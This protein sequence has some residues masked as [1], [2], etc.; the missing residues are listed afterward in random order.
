MVDER[1][2]VADVKSYIDKL[3]NFT[4]E[5]EQH[6][7]NLR[8]DLSVYYDNKL[9]F[10]AEFK[11]PTTIEGRSPRNI[12]VVRDAF[13]KANNNNPPSRFFATSNFNETIIWD[14]SDNTKPLISRDVYTINLDNKIKKDDDFNKNEIKTE[15]ESKMQALAEYIRDLYI[16][17]KK[18]YYKPLGD[19]FILGLN[20]HLNTAV[21]VVKR[22]VPEN[23]LRKWWDEQGY[24]PK[25]T[26]CDE[27][28]EKISKYSLY[29]FANKIVFYY[30]LKRSFNSIGDIK[31]ND[32]ENIKDLENEINN[33][34]E[35]AKK[36]SGDYE[37]VFENNDAD[38]ILFIKDE[39]SYPILLLIKFL[40]VYDFTK[41][42]QELLGNIYDRLIS[43]DERHA[44]GQYYTPIPV[45]DLINALTIKNK[46]SRVMDPACGSGT[47]LTRAFDLK[48][49]L[50]N[51]DNKEIRENIMKEL[52]GCDISAYPA[53]LATIALASKLL[54]YN[55]DVYPN[56]IR[57][58]FLNLKTSNVIPKLRTEFE[59]KKDILTT[60]L[61]GNK[62]IVSFKP[63]DAFVG[64]LPYIRDEDLQNKDA[65][66]EK[67]EKFLKENGFTEAINEN[68]E[69]LYMP[70]KGADFYLYFWYYILPFLKEGSMIG[71]LTSDTWMN[72][73]YGDGFKKFI[74]KY[75]KIKY[76]IDSSV[77]RWF[78]DALVNTVITVLERTNSRTER[79]DN[80]IKFVRINRKISEII[81]D[82]DD[83]IHI[84]ETIEKDEKVDGINII[85]KI[86]QGSI[87]FND[88]MKGKLFPYLRGPE[89]FLEIV[90]NKNM[91][92]INKIMNVN[93]G[94]TTGANQFFYVI[95]VTN[96]YSDEQLKEFFGLRRGERN[97][98]MV[99]KDGMGTVHL[100]EAE[101]L[102]PILKG[103][104]EFTQP[105][106]L[107][108]NDPTKKYVV[109]IEEEDRK[110]IKKHALEYIG[111]GE[112]NPTGEPYSER[113]T[114]KGRKPWWKLSPVVQPDIAITMYFSSNF[115]FPKT[116]FLLDHTLYFGKIRE[117]Y[118]D[119]ILAVYLFLN[120]S[121]SYLYADL[122]GRNYGG[123][124]V[125]FMVYEVQKLPVPRP[126]TMRPYYHELE[127]II[128][129]MEK[130]KIGSVF[131]EIWDIRGS[132]SLNSVKQDRLELDRTILK[133][134]GFENP[135]KF[136]ES[137]Y[138][139][140]VKI[141]KERLDKA[142][143][144]KNNKNTKRTSLNT[145]AGEI[146]KNINVKNFPEDY[147]SNITGN[148]KISKGNKIF[149]GNDLNGYFVSID[150]KKYHH[151]NKSENKYVY[152]CALRGI[153]DV[154]IPDNI[155]NVLKDFESDLQEWKDKLSGEINSITSN[156][157]YR[158]KLWNLCANKLNYDIL[159][160]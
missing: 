42:S 106:K 58:D 147:I 82:L 104:K 28:K 61:S 87:D 150:G 105:G 41:L 26:F 17:T 66:R 20:D 109:L 130:R 34:F 43:P 144:L 95:D 52:F 142:K 21:D 148:E 76:I 55:P 4:A 9:L 141:V 56:I 44:N 140:V 156:D 113:S 45:V 38:R 46:D 23:I 62:K 24:E 12:D 110:K 18:A 36:I 79:E 137:Y 90:N 32:N 153:D 117:E 127:S 22:Y 120:S 8:M 126:E 70:D 155:D 29:V 57:D 116:T 132:F 160:K 124:A 97:K 78:E 84:A 115:I 102:K 85:R 60:D 39:E 108:F 136:L 99:I 50:Y 125:G 94:F 159:I 73:E 158:E 15:L 49:K 100:I 112:K 25:V 122:Y 77:E 118:S 31:I 86:R 74:N 7:D 27:D 83:A 149:S 47:F 98:I 114:C 68:D 107:I 48:L 14:N 40:K 72:V 111:Y 139:E 151:E 33:D 145:V 30:V 96:E 63:I 54:M 75:F 138:V 51:K 35:N 131:D 5:V 133:A 67:V 53:H 135:D 129:R 3:P 134:L 59:E 6:T 80:E 152:Y 128:H 154:P 10:N 146:I 121:L 13:F 2:L 88:T 103:P 157:A 64:N 92:P 11:R 143:S 81:R 89:E 101:Y 91:I 19:S 69:Y 71:F 1:T 37:T 123:G 119:D 16:G 65:E 93:R